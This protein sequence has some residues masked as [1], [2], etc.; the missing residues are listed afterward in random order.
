M[1]EKLHAD[2]LQKYVASFC[3]VST[4]VRLLR[5]ALS[6]LFVRY[7]A[8]VI[9]GAVSQSAVVS[10]DRTQGDRLFNAAREHARHALHSL[11]ALVT[12]GVRGRART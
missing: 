11:G 5:S 2:F 4:D 7:R 8:P 12:A 3:R 6:P 10:K 1:N 9:A